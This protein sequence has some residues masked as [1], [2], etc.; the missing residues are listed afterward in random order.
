MD[1]A[2]HRPVTLLAVHSKIYEKV[3]AEQLS[4]HFEEI[5][6]KYNTFKIDRGLEGGHG[7]EPLCGSSLDG[8]IQGL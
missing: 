3:L 1:K 6:D 2:N 5:V 7:K 8:L 4:E